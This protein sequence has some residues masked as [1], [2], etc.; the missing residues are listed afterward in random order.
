MKRLKSFRTAFIAQGDDGDELE[1]TQGF[2]GTEFYTEV[3]G[4]RIA[5][6]RDGAWVSLEPGWIVETSPDYETTTIKYYDPTMPRR[7]S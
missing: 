2:D 5:V 7:Y 3:S 6:R 1:V 4:K